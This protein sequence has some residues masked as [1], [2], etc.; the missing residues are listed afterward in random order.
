MWFSWFDWVT[1]RN[2]RG[3]KAAA[4]IHE[5]LSSLKAEVSGHLKASAV[6]TNSF[7]ELN[8]SIRATG[9]RTNLRR[10]ESVTNPADDPGVASAF[11]VNTRLRRG[12]REGEQSIYTY[13]DDVHA[14]MLSLGGKRRQASAPSI[15]LPRPINM[16][17]AFSEVI[18]RRRSIRS[19]TGD[20][21]SLSGLSTILT[22]A[23]GVTSQ[24]VV[25]LQDSGSVTLRFRSV[26]SAGALYPIDVVF[27]SINIGGLPRGIYRYEPTE[28]RLLPMFAAERVDALLG[29][30][31]V[32]EEFISIRRSCGIFLLIGQPWRTMRKYGGRGMRF[33]F[34]E[35]GAIGHSVALAVT[36]L[37]YASVDCANV[38]DDEVHEVLDLDGADIAL[39]HLIIFGCPA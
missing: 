13:F 8:S 10:F 32:P 3:P 29:C 14:A 35:A 4:P 28:H 26:A 36:A 33:A 1:G 37:G 5:G 39:F 17:L 20:A 24:A 15:V 6:Y 30:F 23:A 34:M 25:E 38:Y 31:S 7:T 12:D 16:Q 18:A 19:F 27:A 22:A 21:A 11:L 2:T 9:F